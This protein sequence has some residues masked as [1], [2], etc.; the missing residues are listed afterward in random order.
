MGLADFVL[1]DPKTGRLV[2]L[3]SA[4]GGTAG[5]KP[6]VGV[7]VLI[8]RY[9]TD[10]ASFHRLADQQDLILPAGDQGNMLTPFH[11]RGIF[12]GAD[13]TMTIK[14]DPA[15]GARP[16]AVQ[17]AQRDDAENRDPLAP[18]GYEPDMFVN[19]VSANGRDDHPAVRAQDSGDYGV[20]YVFRLQLSGPAAI[21]VQP[22]RNKWPAPVDMYDQHLVLDLDGDVRTVSFRD[23][24]YA[25][26]YRSPGLMQPLGWGRVVFVLPYDGQ[27]HV[28]RTTLPPNGY[29]PYSI[30]IMPDPGGQ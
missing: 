25:G 30:M 9:G 10:F 16:V 2:T 24:G 15:P 3:D 22:A 19:D 5:Q 8:A 4:A 12:S 18:L 23:P 26:Y 28:L 7:E 1:R 21:A 11:Q 13:R 20:Q 14:Y 17:V 29:G 27:T 6:E